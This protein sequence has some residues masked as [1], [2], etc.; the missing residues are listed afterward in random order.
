[1]AS[2]SLVPVEEYLKMSFD[3]REP[4]NLDGELVERHLGSTPHCKAQ[5]HMLEFFQSLQQS[6]S[7]FGYPVVTLEI[8]PTRYRG[9]RT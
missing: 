7:L 4:D 1:M 3:G 6:H 2:K 9:Q 5:E 8:S